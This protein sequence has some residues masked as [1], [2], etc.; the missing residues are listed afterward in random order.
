M[1]IFKKNICSRFSN[2]HVFQGWP[3]RLLKRTPEK[4]L[5]RE[6]TNAGASGY[7]IIFV[8]GAAAGAGAQGAGA[9]SSPATGRLPQS[10]RQL[11]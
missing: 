8:P 5:R 7:L 9:W 6:D 1:G 11:V 10:R 3:K 4:P 2:F